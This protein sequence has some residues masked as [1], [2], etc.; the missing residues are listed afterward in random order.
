MRHRSLDAAEHSASTPR[1]A[2]IPRQDLQVV[3]T[4]TMGQNCVRVPRRSMP[5]K[6]YLCSIRGVPSFKHVGV[7]M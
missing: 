1:A 5:A 7:E 2:R 4:I 6:E 3:W